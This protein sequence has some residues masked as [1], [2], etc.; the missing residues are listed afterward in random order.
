MTAKLARL[1]FGLNEAVPSEATAAWGARW[2]FPCDQLYDRQSGQKLDAAHMEALLD[3]LNAGAAATARATM[4][5]LKDG[6][7]VQSKDDR[8][9][10]LLDDGHGFI[11]ANPRASY[12]YTYV[13]AF[14]RAHVPAGHVPSGERAS[15][16]LRPR[17]PY[18]RQP[19]AEDATT[20]GK[21][22]CATGAAFDARELKRIERNEARAR[23]RKVKTQ[24]RRPGLR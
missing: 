13:C 14:L 23:Q 21:N 24:V 19:R 2:I 22:E 4:Q 8:Q 11:V 16:L 3:W 9:I 5:R 7:H 18:C 20:C 1:E 17:C 10:V 15:T 12:G 6:Y